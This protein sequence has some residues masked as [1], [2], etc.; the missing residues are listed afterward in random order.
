MTMENQPFEDVFPVEK[1]G[2]SQSHVSK[3]GGA[4]SMLNPW[5]LTAFPLLPARIRLAGGHHAV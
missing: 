2:F 3:L 5:I 4:I 1:W